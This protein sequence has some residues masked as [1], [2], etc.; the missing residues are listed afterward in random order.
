MAALWGGNTVS[1]KIGLAG[2]PPLALAGIRFV[3]GGG[4]VLAWALAKRLLLGLARGDRAAMVL[5]AALFLVQIAFL[6]LGI[7]LTLASRSALFLATYPFWTA[8]LAHWFVPGERLSGRTAAGLLLAFSGLILLFGEGLLA[9]RGSLAGDLFALGSGV[10][11]GVRMVYTKRLTAN[12]HPG[13]LLVWQS[14]LSVPAF[15]LLSA[16]IERPETAPIT[17]AVAAAILYQGVIVAGLCFIIQTTLIQ[18]Y[19]PSAVTAFGFA[20]PVFGVLLSALFLGETITIGL[21]ASLALVAAGITVVNRAP[22]VPSSAPQRPA[23][24]E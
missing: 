8:L 6:N 11:L 7:H 10:L 16:L 12:M 15:F 22:R 5:L 4:T 21:A 9:R 2:I 19:S 14:G 13:K 20:T 18:R 1:V 3:L 17:V 23:G 24:A